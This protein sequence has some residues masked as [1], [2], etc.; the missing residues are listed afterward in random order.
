MCIRDSYRDVQIIKSPTLVK[1]SGDTDFKATHVCIPRFF[2][3]I[4]H[5]CE[6]KTCTFQSIGCIQ[7]LVFCID[8]QLTAKVETLQLQKC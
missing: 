6:K 3:Q 5:M 2:S 1:E 4:Q 8:I 7:G